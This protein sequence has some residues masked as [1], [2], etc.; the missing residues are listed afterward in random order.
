MGEP[1]KI[2]Y[3]EQVERVN[4]T[5]PFMAHNHIRAAKLT[6]T[7]AEVTAEVKP[8]SLNAMQGVHGG[9]MFIM[10]EMAAGLATRSDGRRYVTLDSSFRFLRG[11]STAK[12]LSAEAEITKRGKTVCFTKSRVLE[13]ETGKVLAEGEFTFY[14]LDGDEK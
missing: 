5:N 7:T 2:S 11:S 8:E 12:A 13:P 9:L 14:C 3:E 10:A 4:R 6:A 1:G